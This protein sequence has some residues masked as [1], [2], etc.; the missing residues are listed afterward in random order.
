M[1]LFVLVTLFLV[2]TS[3]T[4]AVSTATLMQSNETDAFLSTFTNRLSVLVVVSNTT[5]KQGIVEQHQRLINETQLTRFLDDPTVSPFTPG[6]GVYRHASLRQDGFKLNANITRVIFDFTVVNIGMDVTTNPYLVDVATHLTDI[7][8]GRPRVILSLLLSANPLLWGRPTNALP[9]P[10]L[11]LNALIGD[12][13][14]VVNETTAEPFYWNVFGGISNAGTSASTYTS[15]RADWQSQQSKLPEGERSPVRYGIVYSSSASSAA[16]VYDMRPLAILNDISLTTEANWPTTI[17]LTAITSKAMAEARQPILRDLVIELKKAKLTHMTLYCLTSE[18]VICNEILGWMQTEDVMPSHGLSIPSQTALAMA[19]AVTG[20]Y[21]ITMMGFTTSTQWT[22]GAQS[23][24]HRVN[25]KSLLVEPFVDDPQR[26]IFAPQVWDNYFMTVFPG[27]SFPYTNRIGP[28]ILLLFLLM[29][30]HGAERGCSTVRTLNEC[31]GALILKG[32]QQG[33]VPSPSGECGLSN[34]MASL[35]DWNQGQVQMD[36]A[37]LSISDSKT[38][39]RSPLPIWRDR[40]P[41][42]VYGYSILYAIAVGV[43]MVGSLPITMLLDWIFRTSLILNSS[44][45]TD[46]STGRQRLVAKLT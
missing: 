12:R 23:A 44:K 45:Q 6:A 25:G 41:T 43:T 37:L 40:Q 2:T 11:V 10:P 33:A 16:V 8:Y 21:N 20:K 7:K 38:V 34:Q 18:L 15:W 14:K 9:D 5:V 17:N 30:Q 28:S 26:G 42:I 22:A 19:D 24:M 35:R 32:I 46:E 29:A 27:S 4:S 31:T 3:V 39:F 1:R 36:G 13:R